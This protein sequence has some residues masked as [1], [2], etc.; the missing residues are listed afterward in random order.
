MSQSIEI[1]YNRAT[2]FGTSALFGVVLIGG[3]M[4]SIDASNVLGVLIVVIFIGP[5]F[6]LFATRLLQR[7][8]TLIL[9]D[10]GITVGRSRQVIP[11]ETIFE[12]YLLERQGFVVFHKLMLTIQ[13]ENEPQRE[14]NLSEL[15]TSKVAVQTIEVSLDQLSMSWGEIVK[16]VQDRLGQNI[17]ARRVSALNRSGK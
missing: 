6:V 12:A 8:P 7:R 1:G 2:A 13:G 11:W 4:R 14:A 9:D 5:L 3:A 15:R 17:P 10:N 16:L